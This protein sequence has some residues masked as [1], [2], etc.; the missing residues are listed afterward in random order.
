MPLD[1]LK[2]NRLLVFGSS[3]TYGSHLPDCIPTSTLERTPSAYAWPNILGE[4]MFMPVN[5][6]AIPGASNSEILLTMLTS[7]VF[8][9]DLVV[10]CWTLVNRTYL[11][12]DDASLDK[13]F[14]LSETKPAELFYKL[15][16]DNNLVHHT[17]LDVLHANLF[18]SNKKCN[19]YNFYTDPLIHIKTNSIL[20]SPSLV[21]LDKSKLTVDRGADKM[22][23]G[24]QSH[25]NIAN[26]VYG[27]L[28]E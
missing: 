3:D 20:S 26:Y 11:L 21:Y 9:T 19:I 24:L 1:I 22:H 25:I 4:K 10:V 7:E 13:I 18:F 27:V 12:R 14:P 28:N 6:M 8:E 2:Y 23:P 17:M 16:D 15:Y 5:N